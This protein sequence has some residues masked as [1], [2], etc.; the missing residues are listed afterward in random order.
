MNSA[1]FLKAFPRQLCYWTL[2]CTLNALPSFCIAIVFL[3]LWQNPA[4]VIAMLFAIGNFILLYATLT[5]LGPFGD[6]HHPLSRALRLGAKIRAVISAASIPMVLCGG[7]FV[8][9]DLWC[10]FLAIGIQKEIAVFAGFS[11]PP[12]GYNPSAENSTFLSIY[13]TTLLEGFILSG[14]LLLISFFCVIFLQARD[15]RKFLAMADA[16]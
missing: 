10:G 5:S 16:R 2:H 13:T 11:L 9:P 4:A 14:I 3:E 1:S 7:A 12:N 8:T 6:D 15:R